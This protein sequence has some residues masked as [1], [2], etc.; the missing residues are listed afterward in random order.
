MVVESEM[1]HALP[2]SMSLCAKG[3]GGRGHS[4]KCRMPRVR[5]S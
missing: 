1:H 3:K 4:S 2:R 5:A